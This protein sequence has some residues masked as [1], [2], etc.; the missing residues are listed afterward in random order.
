MVT[1]S[2]I[3][4]F[5]HDEEKLLLC[6]RTHDPY[7]GLIDLPGGKAEDCED[8]LACAYRELFEETGIAPS[9]IHLRHLMDFARPLSGIIVCV[10]FGR[11]N[12][13]VSLI[14]EANPLFWSELSQ[15]FGDPTRYSGS[16]YLLPILAEIA[17]HKDLLDLAHQ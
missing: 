9:D 10:Y 7:K 12:R 13:E 1:V 17:A 8:S 2:V 15:N 16:G 14:E 4:V 5:R 11:L 3:A 6:K